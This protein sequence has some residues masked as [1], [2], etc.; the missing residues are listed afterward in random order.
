MTLSPA[1]ST[2]MRLARQVREQ[3][4]AELIRWLPQLVATMRERLASAAEAPGMGQ[5][6]RQIIETRM[7]FESRRDAWE[8]RVRAALEKSLTQ[9]QK[10]RNAA[11]NPQGTTAFS[12]LDDEVVENKIIA[13]RLSLAIIDKSG[14]DLNDLNVRV[15][16]LE[17]VNELP[18]KDV[19]RPEFLPGILIEQWR[20]CELTRPMWSAVHETVRAALALSITQAYQNANAYLVERGVMPQIDLKSMVRRTASEIG[21]A[22]V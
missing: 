10:P 15:Q 8:Q 20:A 19:L 17:Q 14:T 1:N 16:F 9:I 7:A 6:Q 2:H 12:L 5:G 4:V 22:H 11:T 18:G 21:R 13:S 3:F